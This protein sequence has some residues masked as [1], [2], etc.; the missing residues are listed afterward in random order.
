MVG[1]LRGVLAIVMLVEEL[2]RG[3]FFGFV[4]RSNVSPKNEAN[5]YA[6][7]PW[8]EIISCRFVFYLLLLFDCSQ[9]DTVLVP[10]GFVELLRSLVVTPSISAVYDC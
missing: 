6:V 1:M 5:D 3:S 9:V 4:I 2:H 7:C 8:S 10:S